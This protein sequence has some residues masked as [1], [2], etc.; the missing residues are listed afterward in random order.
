MYVIK[1]GKSN[2]QALVWF[3]KLMLLM[4]FSFV[5]ILY[6]ILPTYMTYGH[7]NYHIDVFLN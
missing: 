6:N 5:T 7:Q 2:A 3:S 4:C 1:I